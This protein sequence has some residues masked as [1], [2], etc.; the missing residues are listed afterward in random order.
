MCLLTLKLLIEVN[1]LAKDYY[2]AGRLSLSA[3]VIAD[4]FLDNRELLYNLEILGKCN[5]DLHRYSEAIDCFKK[6]M[7]M[8]WIVKDMSSELSA[9]D[10]L[11]LCYFYLNEPSKA[12]R[13]HSRF[14]NGD[15]ELENTDLIQ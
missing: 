15:S 13:Y 9:Y 10:N 5:R 8:S 7:F 3:T 2:I 14:I 4:I 6:Q 11:G 12:Q 1:L